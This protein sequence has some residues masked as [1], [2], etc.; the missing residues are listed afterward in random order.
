MT[1]HVPV[2][3]IE[4]TELSLIRSRDIPLAAFIS[5]FTPLVVGKSVDMNEC[6][7]ILPEFS[8][9]VNGYSYNP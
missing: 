4:L 6:V 3:S 7:S 8:Y 2:M 9:E 5:F 1:D